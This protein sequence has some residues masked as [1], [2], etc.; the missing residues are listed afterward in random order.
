MLLAPRGW[1][2]LGHQESPGELAM[3]D[4]MLYIIT[5]EKCANCPAA[6]AVVQEAIEG[7][8]IPMK[9][10]DLQEM[11]PDFEFRL[12]EHQVFIASTPSIILE[13]NGSLK[14]LYN[15]TVPSVEEVRKQLGMS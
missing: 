15:G 2:V 1:G 9:V 12:L 14:M 4:S 8:H 11:D 10:V 3:S 6:K 7:S 13:N 5:Q